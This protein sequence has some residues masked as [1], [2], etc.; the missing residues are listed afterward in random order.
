MHWSNDRALLAMFAY[1]VH[2]PPTL[3]FHSMW[4]GINKD[5]SELFCW[6]ELKFGQCSLLASG[7]V[8]GTKA[9]FSNCHWFCHST[10]AA[11][12]TLFTKQGLVSRFL[13]WIDLKFQLHPMV[14]SLALELFFLIAFLVRSP[15]STPKCTNEFALEGA[16]VQSRCVMSTRDRITTILRARGHV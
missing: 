2:S 14:L 11:Q 1:E 10:H 8:F 12:Q 15:N 3:R 5:M 16:F 4:A 7:A 13:V 6:I 9:A